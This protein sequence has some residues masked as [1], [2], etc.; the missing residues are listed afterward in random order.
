MKASV[1]GHQGASRRI[2]SAGW[3][4][5]RRDSS[6]GL[7]YKGAP[8]GLSLS[9]GLLE[10][11][12]E[13]PRDSLPSL[14]SSRGLTG[15]LTLLPLGRIWI[16]LVLASESLTLSLSF[17]HLSMMPPHDRG[18][19]DFSLSFMLGL[20]SSFSAYGGVLEVRPMELRVPLVLQMDFER[21]LVRKQELIPP[22]KW[23]VSHSASVEQV[24]S[25][26]QMVLWRIPKR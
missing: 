8:E 15:G 26:S 9:K 3:I 1:R 22:V 23:L 25:G 19:K 2:Y 10:L 4:L 14:R 24:P 17:V 11:R 13:W 7:G 6:C 5:V 21:P 12:L 18:M 20:L 16:L